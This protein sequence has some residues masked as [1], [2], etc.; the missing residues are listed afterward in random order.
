[1]P[2]FRIVK[3]AK[4]DGCYKVQRKVFGLFWATTDDF[5]SLKDCEHLV[6]VYLRR[7]QIQID[8]PTDVV[9]K[10]Y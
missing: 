2:K 9:V 10:V 1:M 7:Y 3:M 8:N 5:L 4:R 6:D